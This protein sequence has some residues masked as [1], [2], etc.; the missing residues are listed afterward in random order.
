MTGSN[1][2][3]AE[4]TRQRI[5]EAAREVFAHS[6]L[7]GARVD[8]IAE[9]AGVNKRMLYHYF[10]S[11]KALF[12]AVLEQAYL[13]IRRA[14]QRLNLDRLP[15][16]EALERL[17]R[18]TWE[19]FLAH[20]EFVTLVN[21]ENLH[22]ARHLATLTNLPATTRGLVTMT[23]AIL[24][25]GVAEGSIRPG[26]D[27]VQL[28]LTIAAIGYHYLT[29]RFTGSVLFQTDMMA[30]EALEARLAFNVD[31]VLRLVRA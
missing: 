15:P 6:G 17:V 28:S 31:T 5:L 3:D 26:I 9:R 27:P 29:N 30:P 22:Q 23:R 16:L 12:T 19:Y 21:N 14:E 8:L 2:R 11:K 24:D 7:G 4:A 13:D 20:P 1:R 10:G 25:R 18:F